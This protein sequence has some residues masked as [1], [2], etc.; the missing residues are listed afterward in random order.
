MKRSKHTNTEHFRRDNTA[1]YDADELALLNQVWDAHIAKY[2]SK[3][4][5]F[6]DYLSATLLFALECS[7]FVEDDERR[8]V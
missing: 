4:K 8:E 6:L 3:D 1:G 7:K 2:P 5:C